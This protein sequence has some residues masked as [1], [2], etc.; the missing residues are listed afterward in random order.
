MSGNVFTIGMI[1]VI[2]L[3]YVCMHTQRIQC[4]VINFQEVV[5]MD[6]QNETIEMHQ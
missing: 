6:V 1:L 3:L 2:N 4:S 5:Y